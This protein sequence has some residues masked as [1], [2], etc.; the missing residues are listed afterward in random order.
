MAGKN[1]HGAQHITDS[2]M[3]RIVWSRDHRDHSTRRQL[4]NWQ[5]AGGL[6]LIWNGSNRKNERNLC[7]F[8]Q[9]LF[10]S[11]SFMFQVQNNVN[12]AFDTSCIIFLASVTLCNFNW[13]KCCSIWHTLIY[14]ITDDAFSNDQKYPLVNWEWSN[15]SVLTF[16]TLTFYGSKK[17][18]SLEG[19]KLALLA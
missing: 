13:S 1:W 15:S 4:K 19:L 5:P 9:Y 6:T 10:D 16:I 7:V 14:C 8:V 12:L 3:W 17:C 11:S 18:R 2:L